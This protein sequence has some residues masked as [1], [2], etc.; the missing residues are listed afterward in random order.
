MTLNETKRTSAKLKY[1][2][3]VKDK[4]TSAK[5]VPCNWRKHPQYTLLWLTFDCVYFVVF[6]YHHAPM[7]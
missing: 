7:N 6:S 4:T 2:E 1:A 3:A 5:Q